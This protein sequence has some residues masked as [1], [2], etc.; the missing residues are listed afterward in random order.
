MSRH[1]LALQ[2]APLGVTVNL[3]EPSNYA[4]YER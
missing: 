1:A 3:I 4:S 2:L